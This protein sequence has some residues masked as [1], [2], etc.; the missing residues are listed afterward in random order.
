M[1]LKTAFD[2]LWF[3]LGVRCCPYHIRI[4]T[5]PAFAYRVNARCHLVTL[6]KTIPVLLV[7]EAY[8]DEARDRQKICRVVSEDSKAIL[9]IYAY[10]RVTVFCPVGSCLIGVS[11][12]M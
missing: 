10:A 4:R 7:F 11:I 2:A 1:I 9:P 5:S 3:F 12:S 8:H 6:F